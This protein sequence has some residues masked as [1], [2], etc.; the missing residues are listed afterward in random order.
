MPDISR[1]GIDFQKIARDQAKTLNMLNAR[2]S[3]VDENN[4][5]FNVAADLATQSPDDENLVELQHPKADIRTTEGDLVALSAR[6]GHYPPEEERL[7]LACSVHLTHD[8][9]LDIRTAPP[10]SA[11]HDASAAGDPAVTAEG[12]P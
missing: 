9:R 10:T 3:G 7:D 11:P 5:P 1:S 8:T 2:Y 6:L 4:Q 12:P